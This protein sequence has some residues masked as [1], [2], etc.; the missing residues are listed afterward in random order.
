MGTMIKFTRCRMGLF[1][2]GTPFELNSG[3]PRF[4]SVAKIIKPCNSTINQQRTRKVWRG[5]HSVNWL[6]LNNNELVWM[7]RPVPGRDYIGNNTPG[8]PFTGQKSLTRGSRDPSQAKV[9][10]NETES[11]YFL[12][13]VSNRSPIESSFLPRYPDIRRRRKGGRI[14]QTKEEPSFPRH[15]SF[16]VASYSCGS[17]CG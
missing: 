11:D 13:F 5:S 16:H 12:R 4:A 1:E 9:G 14:K 2:V 7:W 10:R 15:H 8:K 3:R 17:V 6:R